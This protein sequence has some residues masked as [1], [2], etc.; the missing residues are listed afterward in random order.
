MP[1]LL[2]LA[3]PASGKSELR[4]FL[5]GLSPA[6]RASLGLGPMV[7]LDDYPYVHWMREIDRV[8]LQAGTSP[9]F[10]TDLGG[11]FLDP[12][13]WLSLTALLR[14]DIECLRANAASP[15]GRTSPED[16]LRQRLRRSRTAAGMS[17]VA[18]SDADLLPI[19]AEIEQHRLALAA[20]AELTK[21]PH[22]LIVEFSR[23]G[24]ENG[25]LPIPFPRGY[26][27]SLPMLGSGLLHDA[28]ILYLW[29]TPEQ[30]RLKNRERARPGADGSILFH[31]V[32][33]TVMRA[34]Y[35]MDD[36]APLAEHGDRLFRLEADSATFAVPFAAIDNRSDLTSFARGPKDEWSPE[37]RSS[38]F[39]A[40]RAVL[41]P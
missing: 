31:G 6:E 24:A 37:A 8:R 3:L 29:V 22:T 11:G 27:H 2:L 16:W 28:S 4:S 7:Q 30:S 36:L 21:D 9:L 23:G 14:Q 34:E 41:N 1:I 12:R 39:A 25:P 13:E 5:S 33:E 40:L 38:L 20:S 19:A 17:L 18:L 32:P 10:F 15:H 35:G 26:A